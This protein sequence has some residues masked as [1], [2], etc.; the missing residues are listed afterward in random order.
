MHSLLGCELI[1][2]VSCR[3]SIMVMLAKTTLFLPAAEPSYLAYRIKISDGCWQKLH[4]NTKNLERGG[5]NIFFPFKLFIST[6]ATICHST[7]LR[8]QLRPRVG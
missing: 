7:R 1:R 3:P 6:L 2:S 8:V 5:E 4:R